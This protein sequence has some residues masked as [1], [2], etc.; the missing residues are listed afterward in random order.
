MYI[1]TYG[2]LRQD[3]SIDR[4]TGPQLIGKMRFDNIVAPSGLS[5]LA[6]AAGS[7][8]S[9]YLRSDGAVDRTT[10]SHG[11]VNSTMNPPP[12]TTYTQAATGNGHTYILRSDGLC[13]RTSG[14][15]VKL[16][17]QANNDPLKK[18]SSCSVM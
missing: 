9:Y 1:V 13:D 7:D 15:Q 12:G 17:M 8:S 10:G 3:G 6:A 16:T 5:Y 11:K 4:T 2:L 18:A 14:G